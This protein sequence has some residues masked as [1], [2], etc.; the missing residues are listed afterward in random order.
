ME[1]LF[2]ENCILD[3]DGCIGSWSIF[4]FL[5]TELF[6]CIQD[7]GMN[8]LLGIQGRSQSPDSRPL[9]GGGGGRAHLRG[10]GRHPR[11]GNLKF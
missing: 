10:V 9:G 6:V 3:F 7:T 11:Q 8:E 5:S 2:R 4:I 1:T